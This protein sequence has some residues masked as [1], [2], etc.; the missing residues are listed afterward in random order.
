MTQ[1][2]TAS[3]TITKSIFYKHI[4]WRYREPLSQPNIKDTLLLQKQTPQNKELVKWYSWCHNRGSVSSSIHHHG[5]CYHSD[6]GMSSH[7]NDTV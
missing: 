5:S 1:A 2:D 6:I 4:H 7:A 3:N